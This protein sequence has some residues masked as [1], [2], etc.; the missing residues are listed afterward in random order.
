M[1]KGMFL[2]NQNNDP[3]KT[4]VLRNKFANDTASRFNTVKKNTVEYIKNIEDDRFIFETDIQKIEQFNVWFQN[5][6][7]N[8]IL[9]LSDNEYWTNEYVYSA[10]KS[11]TRQANTKLNSQGIETF[12]LEQSLELPINKSSLELLYT[13]T[14]ESLKGVTT[15]MSTQL[16]RS[17]ATGFVN[18]LNPNDI[19]RD[20]NKM[21]VKSIDNPTGKAKMAFIQ[22][23]K[24][25]ARTEV[26]NAHANATLNNFEAAGIEEV[27]VIPEWVTASDACAYC[28]AAASKTYTIKEARGLIPLHPNCRCAW[29]PKVVRKKAS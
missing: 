13:R 11:G 21:F 22:R 8:E 15:E 4:S 18:G 7:D 24:T 9:S 6:I 29:S 25:I 20:I 5:Q 17:L 19:A 16:S 28:L 26:I 10:Y 3:T 1:L 2:F 23:A 27:N 12:K 14:Y